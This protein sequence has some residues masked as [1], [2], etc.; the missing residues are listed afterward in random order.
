MG[1]SLATPY[2]LVM[3][4]LPLQEWYE[5]GTLSITQGLLK[6]GFF[7]LLSGLDYLSRKFCQILLC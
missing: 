3:D 4:S 2:F 5:G 6:N 1:T 7:F